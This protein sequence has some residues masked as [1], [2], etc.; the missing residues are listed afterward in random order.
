M[1]H[2]PKNIIIR[3][4]NGQIKPEVI[5]TTKS[6]VI[7]KHAAAA[8]ACSNRNELATLVDISFCRFR[9]FISA[10]EWFLTGK[11]TISPFEHVTLGL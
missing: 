4:V 3:P 1:S 10:Q 9:L 2:L 11:P 6:R 5:T 7:V 8:A